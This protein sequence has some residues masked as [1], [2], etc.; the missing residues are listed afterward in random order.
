MSLRNYCVHVF[1]MTLFNLAHKYAKQNHLVKKTF[2]VAFTKGAFFQK[3]RFDFQIPN[4]LKKIFQKNY[5]ELTTHI[6]KQLILGI[7]FGEIG[8][9][10]KRI[11][12]YEKN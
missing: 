11:S 2:Q 5:P 1:Y 7:F 8:R 9:F 6:S 10:E 3:V 4:L 12:L